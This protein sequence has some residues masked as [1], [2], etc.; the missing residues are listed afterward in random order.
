MDFHVFIR[1]G[2]NRFGFE[3]GCSQIMLI[4]G[5]YLYNHIAVSFLNQQNSFEMTLIICLSVQRAPQSIS[6]EDIE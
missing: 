2:F 4:N 6:P 1:S 5:K 3:W